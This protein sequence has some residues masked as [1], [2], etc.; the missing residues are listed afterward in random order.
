MP[1]PAWIEFLLLATKRVLT[2]SEIASAQRKLINTFSR[3]TVY[4]PLC[5][6]HKF[7][8]TSMPIPYLALNV[9]PIFSIHV[10]GHLL[11]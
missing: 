7:T 11:Q 5:L 4:H 1:K 2:E 9:F 6:A 3:H 8:L 10:K